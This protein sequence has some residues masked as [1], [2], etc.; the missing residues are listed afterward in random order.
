M[1][2]CTALLRPSAYG[3]APRSRD[4]TG[5]G[6]QTSPRAMVASSSGQGLFPVVVAARSSSKLI[7]RRLVPRLIIWSTMVFKTKPIPKWDVHFGSLA[8][9]RKDSTAPRSTFGPQPGKHRQCGL[10]ICTF[11]LGFSVVRRAPV[12]LPVGGSVVPLRGRL[13][14]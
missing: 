11:H 13:R 6:S 7:S 14:G 4:A 10:A 3:T 2:D 8:D 12:P 9:D 5:C 1:G